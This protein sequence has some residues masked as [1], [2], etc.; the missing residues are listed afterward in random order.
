MID[1]LTIAALTFALIYLVYTINDIKKKPIPKDDVKSRIIKVV[2]AC[3]VI[4]SC[5][6]YHTTLDNEYM[7]YKQANSYIHSL[8]PKKKSAFEKALISQ[9][10]NIE[11]KYSINEWSDKKVD[12]I[13]AIS[14]KNK[15]RFGVYA[16]PM[17]VDEYFDDNAHF[18]A[19]NLEYI[20][21]VVTL[22]IAYWVY[23]RREKE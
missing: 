3:L 8:S 20:G 5:A 11:K 1:Y 13:M 17:K 10:A 16:N 9:K 15:Q 19:D 21:V 2:I 7:E 14:D 4:F 18:I 23:R 12:A 22:G 6:K